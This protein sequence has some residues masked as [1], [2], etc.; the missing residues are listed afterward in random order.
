M[1]NLGPSLP[2]RRQGV[3]HAGCH[4]SSAL[5]LD[6]RITIREC[7]CSRSSMRIQIN[8]DVAEHEIHLASD[9]LCV[10]RCGF[11]FE[12]FSHR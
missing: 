7:N 12:A 3:S 11:S 9:L 8:I 5:Q 2:D 4:F 6:M 1:P 10:L